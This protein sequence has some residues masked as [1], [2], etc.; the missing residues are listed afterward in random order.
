MDKRLLRLTAG[1]LLLFSVGLFAQVKVQ[2][3]ITVGL[4]MFKYHE[5]S[6][7]VGGSYEPDSRT[8]MVAGGLLDIPV[9]KVFSIEPGVV[10]SMRGAYY[11]ESGTDYDPYTG[12]TIAYSYKS[13]LKLSYLAIPVHARL[14]YPG[15]PKVDPYMLAG[16]NF[17]ILLSAK[18]KK[19]ETGSPTVEEDWKSH[20]NGVDFGFDLGVGVELSLQKVIPFVEF[21]YNKG[22]VKIIKNDPGDDF[23]STSKGI[24]IKTG[25]KFRI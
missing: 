14:K 9:A 21:V 20:M 6:E 11:E 2:P 1:A 15:I 8:G 22:L 18:S 19:E 4:S 24:E 13:W 12:Q 7:S 3:G 25:L 10:F 17:G 16:L 5:T 23:F